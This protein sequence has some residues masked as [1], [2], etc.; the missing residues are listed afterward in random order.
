MKKLILLLSVVT[1]FA[2]CSNKVE[3]IPGGY[4]GKLLTPTG[5]DKDIL[6]AGQVD[7]GVISSN[8]QYTSL[9]LLEASTITVKESFGQATDSV[10]ED[11]RVMT[12]TAPLTVDIYVQLSVPKEIKLRN[13]AFAC[14]TPKAVSERVSSI[15]LSSIYDQF[16]KMTVRGR[17]RGIFAKYND[18]KEVM[19][20]YEK[21][22]AEI[23]F[24]FYP[25]V[26]RSAQ[27]PKLKVQSIEALGDAIRKNAGYLSIRKWE[28]LE[29]IISSPNSARINLIVSDDK[30]QGP[31]VTVATE[32]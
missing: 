23:A 21:V 2:S 32:N 24:I 4:I 28:V 14:I 30:N 26:Q 13:N 18:W 12:K 27:L 29:K 6:E 20:N 22:N 15:S 9:V 31:I 7:I 16:A 8:G 1:L 5:W 19:D 11:H 25:L 17:V 3:N 10:K